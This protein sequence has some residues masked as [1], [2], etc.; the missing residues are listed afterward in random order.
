MLDLEE[1]TL[2]T[3]IAILAFAFVTLAWL[4]CAAN[5]RM[6]MDLARERQLR[7]AANRLAMT[8]TTKADELEARLA[9][10]ERP[11]SPFKPSFPVNPSSNTIRT[12]P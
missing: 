11:Q 4:L 8:M 2:W 5:L 12:Q 9:T 10:Y 6:M 7:M 1:R 3:T